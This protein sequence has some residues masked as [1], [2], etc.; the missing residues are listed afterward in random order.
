[1]KR[2]INYLWGF[3]F[4]VMGTIFGLNA[5]DIVHIDIFFDGWWT[6][7]IIV[8]CLVNL[9]CDENKV[10]DLIGLFVGVCLL[11]GAQGI[12]QIQFLWKLMVPVILVVIGI[13]FFMKDK[14]YSK[15]KNSF[16]DG[17]EIYA[18]FSEQ[19]LDYSYEDFYGCSFN[20]VFGSIQCDL[21]DSKIKEDVVVHATSVFGGIT[22][23]VPDDV[24]I[25]VVSTSIFGGVSDKRHH[26]SKKSDVTI[27][28]DVTCL[29]G[30]VD[31]K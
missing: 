18:T 1:M 24:R 7:F 13:S 29:F 5:L 16:R 20:A 17:G 26:I 10:G 25:R 23:L 22:L 2:Y 9:F 19:K 30:G 8:P 28:L 15:V 14:I 12:I 6:L 4:I 3:F 11:L 27:Y 31:I 21:K